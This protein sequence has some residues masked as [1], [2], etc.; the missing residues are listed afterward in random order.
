MISRHYGKRPS[1]YD[2]TL[3]SG[4][5]HYVESFERGNDSKGPLL[6]TVASGTGR[7]STAVVEVPIYV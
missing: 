7:L 3:Q 6:R 1:E 4:E 2:L 5:T